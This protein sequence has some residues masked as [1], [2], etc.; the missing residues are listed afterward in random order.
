MVSSGL[1]LRSVDSSKIWLA[2]ESHG[3]GV[4]PCLFVLLMEV[5]TG[6]NGGTKEVHVT[7]SRAFRIE[8]KS[9]YL[10]RHYLVSQPCRPS[11]SP[12]GTLSLRI[13]QGRW[14]LDFCSLAFGGG[15]GGG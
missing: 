11:T 7:F 3:E 12:A 5:C 13:D 4:V 10:A 2:V 9:Y 15:A 1:K 6:C 14:S 8:F